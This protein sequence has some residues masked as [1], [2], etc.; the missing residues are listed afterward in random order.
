MITW[1]DFEQTSKNVT[2][3]FED[4][5]RLFFK[6]HF[7][8]DVAASLGKRVNNAGIETDPVCVHNVRIGFQA[9]YFQNKISYKDII[10]SFQ[11]TIK[12]YAGKIDLIILFCNKDINPNVKSFAY[13]VDL[14]AK[15][16][17]KL[18]F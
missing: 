16:Q 18:E 8:G 7:L 15:N 14:L 6:I 5:S 11:K 1:N 4:L 2:T 13:A 12:Y 10:D 3:D 9:K 17:I